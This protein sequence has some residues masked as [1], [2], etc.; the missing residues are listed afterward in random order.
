LVT[1]DRINTIYSMEGKPMKWYIIILLLLILSVVIYAQYSK[2]Y[3]EGTCDERHGKDNWVW[4]TNPCN[5]RITP[6]IECLIR[7]CVATNDR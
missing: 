2:G 1:R 5:D 7:F 4:A 3:I 6:E